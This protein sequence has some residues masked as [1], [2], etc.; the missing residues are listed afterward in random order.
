[1]K[2]TSVIACAALSLLAISCGSV[3][4]VKINMGDQCFRCRR[5]INDVQIAA[6][7]IGKSGLVSKFKGA[8][9][10]AKYLARNPLGEGDAAFVTD[11]VSG[12]MIAPERARF[13]KVIVD[14][15]AGEQDFRAYRDS[16]QADAAALE[17]KTTTTSWQ[18]VLDFGRSQ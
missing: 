9:C 13:V 16:R 2:P 10:M 11:Y 6:E 1:M 14:P 4:P 3:Q 5:T 7:T 12:N 17:F 15:N 18:G 8:G